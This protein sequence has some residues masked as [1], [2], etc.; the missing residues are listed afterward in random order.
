MV[1]VHIPR[2]TR[3]T[4]CGESAVL[5]RD[6]DHFCPWTG[7][8]IAGGNL[9]A[10][11]CHRTLSFGQVSGVD[12]WPLSDS[13]CAVW[14]VLLSHVRL[15]AVRAVYLRIHRRAQRCRDR[16]GAEPRGAEQRREQPALN[17][18]VGNG[19]L[20]VRRTLLPKTGAARPADRQTSLPA[21]PHDRAQASATASLKPLR[22]QQLH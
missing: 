19:N 9:C 21:A 1:A 11:L 12:T 14:Q 5:V 3:T 7:N 15:R 8:T 10:H 18:L 22:Q 6:Y 16:G 20:L 2:Q 13:G 17:W 4:W